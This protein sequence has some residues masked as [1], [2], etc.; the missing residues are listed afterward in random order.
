MIMDGL[1]SYNDYVR[2]IKEYGRKANTSQKWQQQSPSSNASLTF[3]YADTDELD[4]PHN[5]PLFIELL[6]RDCEMT[7]ILVDTGSSV[8]LIFKET[9]DK[10]SIKDAKVKPGTKP[11]T[12]FTG[13]TTMTMETIKLPVYIEGINK[14]VKFSILD[15]PAIYNVILGTPWTHAM[16]AV[17]LTYNQCVKFPTPDGAN[18]IRGN[19]RM[20]RTCFVSEKKTK[21]E[22][23]PTYPRIRRTLRS[24]SRI[25]KSKV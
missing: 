6:V 1:Q 13:E 3:T 23:N 7:Y 10:M 4:K 15:K 9:L 11:L 19:Q 21:D 17:A 14:L 12:G 22:V 20:S 25:G 8:D 16:G 24:R 5:N 2:S 18:T